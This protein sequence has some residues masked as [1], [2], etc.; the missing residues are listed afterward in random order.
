MEANGVVVR[1]FSDYSTHTSENSR[2]CFTNRTTMP[3][4]TG[5][6]LFKLCVVDKD[7]RHC[8]YRSSNPNNSWAS[9]L[10]GLLA[11]ILCPLVAIAWGLAYY[12]LIIKVLVRM[13]RE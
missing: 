8:N 13:V 5:D 1:K 10:F 11:L 2:V 4:K 12:V 7:I 6:V 9:L 3:A